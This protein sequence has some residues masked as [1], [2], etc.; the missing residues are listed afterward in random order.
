MLWLLNWVNKRHKFNWFFFIYCYN[1]H[2]RTLFSNKHF[3][4]LFH[5]LPIR[6]LLPFSFFFCRH[7]LPFTKITVVQAVYPYTIHDNKPSSLY[8]NLIK[9]HKIKPNLYYFWLGG[10]TTAWQRPKN[11][12]PYWTKPQNNIIIGILS[13]IEKSTR[14]LLY[15]IR[16]C[17]D[18]WKTVF[19]ISFVNILWLWQLFVKMREGDPN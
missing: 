10:W 5:L 14:K 3:T 19:S 8:V 4:K 16:L 15:T 2:R 9:P 13:H 1:T 11:P 7:Q 17:S 12:H 6:R 18:N